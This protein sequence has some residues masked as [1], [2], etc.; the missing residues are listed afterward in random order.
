M[1][2]KSVTAKYI[3]HDTAGTRKV[4]K[5]KGLDEIEQGWEF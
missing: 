5:D 3:R 2:D 1:L 4:R